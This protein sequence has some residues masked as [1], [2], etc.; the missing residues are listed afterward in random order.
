MTTPSKRP[1]RL[2]GASGSALLL[3]T[4]LSAGACLLL[5]R[6]GPAEARPQPPAPARGEAAARPRTDQYGDPLPEGALVRFGSVR[7]R[8]ACADCVLSPDGKTLATSGGTLFELSTGRPVRYLEPTDDSVGVSDVCFSPDGELLAGVG[9]AYEWKGLGHF[10]VDREA[11]LYVWDGGTGRVL[12]RI[13]SVVDKTSGKGPRTYCVAFGPT[14]KEVLLFIRSGELRSFDVSTGKQRWKVDTDGGAWICDTMFAVRSPG[15]QLLAVPERDTQKAVLLLSTAT[16]ACVRRIAVPRLVRGFRFSPDGRTLAVRVDDAHVFLYD[17]KSGKERIS[18]W[19]APAIPGR[20]YGDQPVPYTDKRYREWLSDVA[21]S[22]DGRTLFAWTSDGSILR[23]DAVTGAARPPLVPRSGAPCDGTAGRLLVTPDGRTLVAVGVKGDGIRRWDLTTERVIAAVDGFKYF[24]RSRLSPDGRR[25]A[26]GDDAGRLELC[27]AS[28]RTLRVLRKA[29]MPVTGL[30][31]SPD[32]SLLAVDQTN[33]TLWETAS[34]RALRVFGTEDESKLPNGGDASVSLLAF[35]PDGRFLLTCTPL[36]KW[37]LRCR[38]VST[39]KE[40]WNREA[41]GPTAVFSQ[42]GKTVA[43]FYSDAQPSEGVATL[44]AGTGAVRA[45]TEFERERVNPH[46]QFVIS[47][48][49][50]WWAV[51]PYETWIEIR[52]RRTGVE[53]KRLQGPKNAYCW[54][55][56]PSPDG[57]WIV[58]GWD[59]GSFHIH[60]VATGRDLFCRKGHRGSVCDVSFNAGQRTALSS[61][62]DGTSLL[63]DL[64]QPTAARSAGSA[65][66]WNDLAS[67]DGAVI[68]RAIWELCDNPGPAVALLREKLPP[69]A[70]A[71]E[72]AVQRLVGDLDSDSF[73]QRE[74]AERELAA[75]GP[76]IVS[77]LKQLLAAADSPEVRRR[78]EKLVSV[79]APE[80]GPEDFRRQ[81]AVQALELAGT[82]EARTLLAEWAA[83]LAGAPLTVDSRAALERL[84]RTDKQT[85]TPGK[86]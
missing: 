72:K 8:A 39:G 42:D 54:V 20:N 21:F 13:P 71:L 19:L 60:E 82:P 28:G 53:R 66:L 81:R 48:D 1:V 17:V 58:S 49:G 24:L 47:P 30:C 67:E 43:A 11:H 73:R 25:V 22:A 45:A 44:D 35:S 77:R 41:Y 15:G 64:H 63:W 31:W 85:S 3:L 16:G 56:T 40:A 70:P 76:G 29:G 38:E 5:W 12:R 14:G 2:V 52:D 57:K 26:I 46:E 51:H 18:F 36:D 78:L 75:L 50:D 74:R 62:N 65:S 80:P 86:P 83:G 68:Y 7:D 9:V 69:A 34:G 6:A 84:R 79:K 23:R 33:T 27:E 4:G 59:D 10:Y 32:G 37:T 61:S 55:C